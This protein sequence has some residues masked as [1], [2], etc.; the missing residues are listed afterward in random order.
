L[1]LRKYKKIRQ[2]SRIPLKHNNNVETNSKIF[3]FT[4][5]SKEFLNANKFSVSKPTG[6][7]YSINKFIRNFF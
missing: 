6:F 2:K 3:A 5:I 1:V 4:I 7:T